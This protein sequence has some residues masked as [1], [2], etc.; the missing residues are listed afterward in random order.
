MTGIP[1]PDGTRYDSACSAALIAPQWIVT[2][3][4]CF[5]DVN[6]NPVSGAVPYPTTATVGKTDLAD[7]TGHVV[8]VTRVVQ[9]SSG[10][11]ALAKLAVAVRDVAPLAVATGA[12][13]VGELVTL[14]GWGATDSVNPTPS[15]HLNYGVFRIARIASTTVLVDGYAPRADTSACMYD[16]GAP[17]FA[18][19]VSGSPKLVS[20]ESSGPDCPHTGDETTSR[21][22]RLAGWIRAT[23]R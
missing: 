12:P 6:R 3:G 17:Y 18:V 10:D 4:H 8:A 15:S 1:R 20:V 22:D 14:A 2:A 5:H 19:P 21:T 7:A 23:A 11:V 13:V 16:S 9:A